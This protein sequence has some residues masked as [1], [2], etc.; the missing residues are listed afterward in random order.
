M[1]TTSHTS[2]SADAL[3][4]PVQAHFW[5]RHPIISGALG[6]LL[7]G[8]LMRLWM[9]FVSTDPEFTWSG[10]GFIL[11]AALIAGLGLGSAYALSR[12]TRAGWWRLFGLSVILLGGG[13]GIIMIPGVILGGLAFARRNW[14]KAVRVSLWVVAS[15]G[16]IALIGL[17]SDDTFGPIKTTASMAIFAVL[18]T[19]EMAA[20]GIAFQETRLSPLSP[21][22]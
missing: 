19:I 11:G 13:A 2:Y 1:D 6:G 8:V 21:R 7:W 10:T 17:S 12:K 5:N 9:R 22:R 14:P 16:T 4:E 15:G 18:H 3:A 20:I